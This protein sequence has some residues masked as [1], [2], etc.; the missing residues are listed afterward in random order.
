MQAEC[1]DCRREI[2]VAHGVTRVSCECGGTFVLSAIEEGGAFRG[3]AR[4]ELRA[5]E[6]GPPSLVTDEKQGGAR[7]ITVR[8]AVPFS[9]RAAVG[10][11]TSR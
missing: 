8:D 11:V 4:V 7:V 6:T 2:E 3:D 5:E 9:P 1:P 10:A